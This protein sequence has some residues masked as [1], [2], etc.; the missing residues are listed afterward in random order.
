MHMFHS[1]F[2]CEKEYASQMVHIFKPPNQ[3]KFFR[4]KAK[5][6]KEVITSTKEQERKFKL[7]YLPFK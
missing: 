6:F 2:W 7:K 5:Y 3:D 4:N 1:Q